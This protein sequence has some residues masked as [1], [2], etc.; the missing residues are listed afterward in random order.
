M[1]RGRAAVILGVAIDA[2]PEQV[3]DAYRRRA[4]DVHPDLV[5]GDGAAMAVLNAAYAVLSR[6]ATT[7]PDWEF[8]DRRAETDWIDRSVDDADL[9]DDSADAGGSHSGAL[10][11]FGFA[12]FVAGVVLTTIVF[13][14]AVGYDWSVSP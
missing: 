9:L 1:E 14:A 7:E 10:R 11:W 5:P 8:G 2:T 12:L 4:R 13:V 3:R 6:P